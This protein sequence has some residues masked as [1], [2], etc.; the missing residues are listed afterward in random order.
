VVLPLLSPTVF[1]NTLLA[2]IGSFQVFGLIYT[3]TGGGP[4]DSTNVL[5]LN[6]YRKAFGTFPFEMGYASAI[7][8]VLFL[9]LFAL[10][11]LQWVLRRRW[12]LEET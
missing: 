4:L 9:I 7:A 10:T 11:Y 6:L 3:M 5:M 8:W 1:L 12:V 2:M